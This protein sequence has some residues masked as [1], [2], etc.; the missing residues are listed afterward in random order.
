MENKK[1]FN[2][3]IIILPI[4]VI[5]IAVITY[6][7]FFYKKDTN[8]LVQNI[9][10]GS[11]DS[12]K[13]NGWDDYSVFIDGNEIKLPMKFSEFEAMGFY[14]MDNNCNVLTNLVEANSSFGSTQSTGKYGLFSNGTTSNI[15]LLI[16]NNSNEQK[17][18]KDCYIWGI[19][20]AADLRRE[21]YLKVG[22]VKIIDNTKNAEA[23]IGKSKYEDIKNSFG[24]HYQYNYTNELTYYPDLNSDG[25]IG[26]EDLDFDRSLSMWFDN[27]TKILDPYEFSY[28]DI[29]NL[30]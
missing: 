4:L 23:I 2:V 21:E 12:N 13:V 1:K 26:M 14:L 19:G 11:I 7:V 18:V 22:E 15:F 16:Y 6:F 5:I 24:P 20:F 30:K 17:E 9:N 3:L 27:D 10:K 8:N 29:G 28:R 25:V